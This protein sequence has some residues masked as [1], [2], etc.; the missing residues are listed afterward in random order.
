MLD[1][2]AYAAAWEKKRAW[3]AEQGVTE[4]GGPLGVLFTTDDREGVD[5]PRWRE[6]AREIIGKARVSSPRAVKRV[7]AKKKR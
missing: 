4:A 3:Y 6:Q 7:A 5:E 2:P 1:N